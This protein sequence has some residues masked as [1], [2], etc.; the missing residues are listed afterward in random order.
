MLHDKVFLNKLINSRLNGIT[1]SLNNDLR[2][3]TISGLKGTY[4]Y[5]LANLISRSVNRPYLYVFDSKDDREVVSKNLNFFI[6]KEI[7]AFSRKTLSK[8]SLIDK[9][10]D[11]N[12]HQRLSTLISIINNQPLCTEAAS[13][14]E[15]VIPNKILRGCSIEINVKDKVER[16]EF[17]IQLTEYGYRKSDFVTS[18][19]EMSVRGSIVDLYSSGHDFPLRIEY[20]GDEIRSIRYF[21]SN[22]QKSL[23]KLRST[24]IHPVSEFVPYDNSES[25]H[26]K[27]VEVANRRGVS[28]QLKN[29]FLDLIKNRVYTDELE[30]LVPYIYN[31]RD[32]ILNFMDESYL[33]FLDMDNSLETEFESIYKTVNKDGIKSHQKFYEFLPDPEEYYFTPDEINK[34]LTGFQT[35]KINDLITRSENHFNFQSHNSRLQPSDVKSPVQNL[36]ENLRELIKKQFEIF[37]VSYNEN[38]QSKLKELLSDYNIEK[39]NYLIGDIETGFISDDLK[40]AVFCESDFSEKYKIPDYKIEKNISSV[41]ISNFSK[42]KTGDFIVHKNFGIGIYNGLKKLEVNNKKSDFLECEYKDGNKLFVPV[43]NLKLIQR[44]VGGKTAPAIDKL[45]GSGWKRKISK[46]KR[47]VD[48][49]AKEL[50]ELYAKRKAIK[51]FKFSKRDHVFKEFEIEFEFEETAD[52]SKAIEDVMSDMEKSKPMDRLICG[53][54]GFGKTEIAMRASFKA[55]MDGKQTAF[56]VPTTLLAS[57]HYDNFKNRFRNHPINIEVIS[58]FKTATESKKILKQLS[59]GLIDIM[60]GTHKLLGERIKFKNLGLV[61]IDEEHKFGVRHKEKLRLISNGVDVVSLSATPIPRS[62]QLSL[63]NIRDISLVNTPPEGRMPV[64]VY[65]DNYNEKV[66]R[67]AVMKELARNGL[68]LFI[69]NRIRNISEVAENLKTLIPEASIEITHGQMNE[70]TLENR[71]SLFRDGKI[72]LLVTTAIVESGL[73]IPKANTIIV[74]DSHK[75]GL[76]DLYQLKGRVGRGKIKAH[77]YFL[78]PSINTLSADARKRLTKLSELQNMGTGFKLALYDMEIRGAGSLFGEEQSGTISEVGLELYLEMLQET[79]R[80]FNRHKEAE[81]YDPEIQSYESAFIPENYIENNSERLYYYKRFSSYNKLKEL[82]EIKEEI[83][84]KFGKIPKELNTLI[85]ILELKFRIKKVRIS[86]LEIQKNH[87]LFVLKNDSILYKK[88]KLP[89]KIKIYYEEYNKYSEIHKK[90]RELNNKSITSKM[91]NT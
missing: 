4:K 60:I 26:N 7:P 76:A 52:Q 85:K 81:D 3:L 16:D 79:I 21:S 75:F 24:I 22:S 82:N 11:N 30:H 1:T 59:D 90:L 56:L 2:S 89:E 48:K 5:L 68:V 74:N 71:I 33:V 55:A 41:F 12:R 37:I 32:N 72:N 35:I 88:F 91:V 78:V 80:N 15:P 6:K 28:A 57:Q 29:T 65:I 42:L 49:I 70:K 77:A 69:N 20:E 40:L 84:D 45:G 50:L 86:K 46:V 38:E 10:A 66:I 19:C 73:D 62:L 87:A 34:K 27:I 64:N 8:R 58:R 17:I 31:E 23:N 18:P 25:L 53:D 54:T 9:S 83:I 51:G 67:E 14:F 36:A 61:I 13:L 63:T 44:Y 47:A 43:E 39:I